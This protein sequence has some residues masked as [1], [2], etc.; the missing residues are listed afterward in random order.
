[1]ETERPPTLDIDGVLANFVGGMLETCRDM[2]FPEQELV[3]HWTH[4][5]SWDAISEEAFAAAWSRI[6]DDFAWWLDLEPYGD[7]Y[8][9]TGVNAYVTSRPIP[10]SVSRD[11]LLMNGFPDAPVYTVGPGNSKKEALQSAGADVF[12]D[13]RPKNAREANQVEGV[14]GVLLSRPWNEGEGASRS[15]QTISQLT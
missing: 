5:K 12:V 1:M 9:D 2:G 4:W 10:S 13:D 3:P 7:A 6:E 11:W 14:T 8:V 15:I